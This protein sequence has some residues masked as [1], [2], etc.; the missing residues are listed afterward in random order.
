MRSTLELEPSKWIVRTF[1]SWV[2][3]R[4]GKF[5]EAIAELNTARQ[6]DDNHYV[7]G[8]LGQAYALSGK[9]KEALAC[10][11]QLKEWS[12]QRY[13]Y[14]HSIAMIYAGLGDK[15]PAF[16]WLEKAI[17]ARSEH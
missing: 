3:V 1:L 9:K 10:I 16:E 11:A 17:A 13:V 4:Q 15:Y 14:P 5:S 6:I 8:A 7:V 2:L 12:K